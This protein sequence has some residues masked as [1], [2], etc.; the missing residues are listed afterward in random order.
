MHCMLYH[1]F[2]IERRTLEGKLCFSPKQTAK[3]KK[4]Y[5]KE[6]KG[7][8]SNSWVSLR[9][10][11]SFLKAFQKPLGSLHLILVSGIHTQKPLDLYVSDY[12]KLLVNKTH[13]MLSSC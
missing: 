6:E 4:Q 9:Y 10:G 2:T 3:K 13:N 7:L 8:E 5:E 12:I 1:Y 11:V